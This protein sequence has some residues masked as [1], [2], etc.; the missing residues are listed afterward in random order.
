MTTEFIL[1]IEEPLLVE[2]AYAVLEPGHCPQCLDWSTGIHNWWSD[3][4]TVE[5]QSQIMDIVNHYQEGK[6]HAE[7]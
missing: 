5:G 6:S 2:Q 1:N 4:E 3:P 7:Q